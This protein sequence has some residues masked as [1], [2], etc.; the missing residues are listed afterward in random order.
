MYAIRANR[1]LF[2]NINNNTNENASGSNQVTVTVNAG[3]FASINCNVS[4]DIND[5]EESTSNDDASTSNSVPN[6]SAMPSL[7]PTPTF[8]SSLMN[9]NYA[10]ENPMLYDSA[11]SLGMS[12]HS[13]SN[14]GDSMESLSSTASDE[15]KRADPKRKDSGITKDVSTNDANSDAS[16]DANES[17]DDVP[18]DVAS[19]SKSID[20]EKVGLAALNNCTFDYWKSIGSNANCSNAEPD[21]AV[22]DDVSK[23]EQENDTDAGKNQVIIKLQPLFCK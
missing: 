15:R 21:A 4:V 7:A 23:K 13:S 11:L 12:D 8:G 1:N 6:N 22:S 3:S 9:V 17:K 19:T 14:D 20:K 10:M 18:K 5:A 16:S 2:V